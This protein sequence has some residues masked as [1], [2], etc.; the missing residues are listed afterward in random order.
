MTPSAPTRRG[1]GDYRQSLHACARGAVLLV[2]FMVSLLAVAAPGEASSASRGCAYDGATHLAQSA[3]KARATAQSQTPI[4]RSGRAIDGPRV[5]GDLW[6]TGVAANTAPVGSRVESKT[7]YDEAG[8]VT[9]QAKYG[10]EVTVAPGTNS[11]AVIAGRPCSGH[12]LDQMQSRGIVP[13]AVE[14]DIGYGTSAPSRGGTSVLYSSSNNLSVVV[15]SEGRVVTTSFG[16]L[17]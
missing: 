3:N 5:V 2:L 11:P 10:W 17:G 6:R 14:D 15:N 8:N 12:A 7:F 1:I 13:S 9:G 16:D 4:S